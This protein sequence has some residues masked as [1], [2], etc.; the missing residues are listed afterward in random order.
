L[1]SAD[2]DDHSLAIFKHHANLLDLK[3]ASSACYLC[4]EIWRTFCDN[5]GL[6]VDVSEA[7][8]SSGLSD[9]PLYAIFGDEESQP[10]RLPKL[11]ILQHGRHELTRII[12]SFDI[13][14]SQDS[15]PSDVDYRFARVLHP[16]SGSEECLSLVREWMDFCEIHH[17][18]CKEHRGGLQSPARLIDLQGDAHLIDATGE[19][20]FVALSYSWGGESASMLTADT[21]KQLRGQLPSEAL[22]PTMRDAVFITNKLGIRYLWIDAICIFQDSEDDFIA[23]NR[24]MRDIYSGAILTINGTSA[25][26]ISDS[27]FVHRTFRHVKVPWRNGKKPQEY[28][29]LREESQATQYKLKSAPVNTRGWCLQESLLARRSLWIGEQQMMFECAVNQ[30]DESGRRAVATEDYRSKLFINSL[31]K[32]EKSWFKSWL[33]RALGI[34]SVTFIPFVFVFWRTFLR[35]WDIWKL[36]RRWCVPLLYSPYKIDGS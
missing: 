21:E 11:A 20:V 1:D 12:A 30:V 25:A 28:V 29:Y 15:Q 33:F 6:L 3:R 2:L 17:R 19:E 14:I 18:S 4:H 32:Q 5:A 16:Y 34:P 7:D 27:L 35:T 10:D 9:Q 23:E 8:L 22:P 36:F 26:K 31:L 24:K 13:C